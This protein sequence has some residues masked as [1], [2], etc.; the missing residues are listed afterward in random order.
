MLGIETFFF[1][2]CDFLNISDEIISLILVQK[3]I[4]FFGKKIDFLVLERWSD[5]L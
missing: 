1:R 3:K 4:K 2:F 5:G